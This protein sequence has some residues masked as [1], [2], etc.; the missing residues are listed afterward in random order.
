MYKRHFVSLGFVL[1]AGTISVVQAAEIA[2]LIPTGRINE[3]SSVKARFS[4]PVIR[5]GRADSPDPLLVKCDHPTLKGHGKWSDPSN[6][7]YDF[8]GRV[9]S[10]VT[11]TITPNA[12]FRDLQGKAV[13][14]NSKYT[15]NTGGPRVDYVV[16]YGDQVDEEQ[17]FVI[18]FTAPVNPQSLAQKAVCTATGYG[19]QIPVR[20][21]D[22][23]EKL[24]LLKGSLDYLLDR[25][26][27]VEVVQCSRRLPASGKMQLFIDKGLKG[28]S[29][30]LSELPYE[31]NYE[32]REPFKVSFSCLRENQN[33]ACMPVKPVSLSFNA[34]VPL[35]QAKAIQLEV[36]GKIHSP[37]WQDDDDAPENLV[38]SVRFMPPF[39]ENVAMRVILP[40][41]FRDDAGRV[42]SNA[43]QFPLKSSFGRT[44]PLVKFASSTFGIIE[45]HA[46][47]EPGKSLKE[48]PALVPLTVRNV[49]SNLQADDHLVSPGQVSDFV[50]QS[51]QDVLNW[52]YRVRRLEEA[53]YSPANIRAIMNDQAINWG[54]EDQKTEIDTRSVSILSNKEGV[55]KVDLPASGKNNERE[56]EVIGLPLRQPGFHVLEVKSAHLGQ[57]L[58]KDRNLMYVRTSVLLTN[59]G[60]HVKKGKD[61]FLVWVTTLDDAKPIANA[62]VNVLACDGQ[63]VA[64]GQTDEQGIWHLRKAVKGKDY[65]ESNGMS[66]YFVSARLPENHPMANGVPDYSFAFTSW[67]RGIEPWRFNVPMGY[68]SD[69]LDLKTH[70]VFDRSLFRAGETVSMK[71]FIRTETRDGFALPDVERRPKQLTISHIGSSDTYEIPVEWQPTPSGGLSAVSSWTIPKSAKLGEY[72]ARFDSVGND[73]FSGANFRVEAFKLPLLTGSLKI[74]QPGQEGKAIVAPHKLDLDLQ[75]NYIAGGAAGMLPVTVSAMARDRSVSFADYTDFS[76]EPPRS[77][78][79]DNAYGQPDSA[80]KLFVDK[81]R[82]VLDDKGGARVEITPVPEVKQAKTFTFE[83]SFMD[84]NGEIQTLSQQV[85]AWPANIV[86]GIRTGYYIEKGKNAKIT[87]LAL[88]PAGK[89]VGQTDIRVQA[90]KYTS[91]TVRKRLVGGFYSYDTQQL[92]QDMGTV[93]EG[94]TDKDGRLECE[95]ALAETGRLSLIAEVRDEQGN[96]SRAESGVWVI[97][98]EEL[99]FAGENNDRIDIIPERKEYSAGDKARFQV[100]MPFRQATALLAVEREGVLEARVVNIDGKDPTVSIDIKPEWGPNV[101]VSVLALR[102]RVRSSPGLSLFNW[103]KDTEEVAAPTAMIDLAKPAFRFGLTDIRVQSPAHK[104]YIQLS[105]NKEQYKIRETAQATIK[106]VLPDGKPAA[107]ATVAVAVV[108]QALLELS[109]N[110]SWE[111]LK[112]MMGIRPYSVETATAQL[113]IVGRRHYGRKALPPGG[114]GGI[115]APTR[116]LLDTLLLWKPDIVLDEQGQATIDIPL[117]DVIS[118]FKV[119]A[120]ADHG[121]QLFGDEAVFINTTQDLQIISGLP[122]VVREGD[123][124]QAMVTVRNSSIRDMKMRVQASFTGTAV[125]AQSLPARELALA[126]GSSGQVSWDVLVPTS[127]SIQDNLKL[128]WTL[129]VAETETGDAL[130]QLRFTQAVSPATPVTVRQAAL[131]S[132]TPEAPVNDLQLQVPPESLRKSGRV[133]GG[134]QVQLQPTLSN[135]LQ[136]VRKWFNN[137][138][139]TC[140]EQVSSIAVGLHSPEKWQAIMEQLPSYL[141]QDGLAMYFPSAVLNGDVVLTAYLVSMADEAQKLGIVDGIPAAYRERMLEGLQNYV[142]GKLR[143]N[144][145]APVNDNVERRVLALEALSRYGMVTPSLLTAVKLD[146]QNWSTAALVDWMNIVTRVKGMPN[147]AQMLERIRHALIARMDR[148]GTAMVFADTG[149]NSSWWLMLNNEANMAKLLLAVMGNKAWE[150][151]IPY[152]L[153][154]L[155][156]MQQQGAWST[157]TANLWGTLAVG[158]FSRKFEKTPAQGSVNMTLVPQSGETQ[159]WDN[160]SLNQKVFAPWSNAG[161]ESLSLAKQGPGRVWAT[162]SALA[163]V[164]VTQPA[165]AGYVIEKNIEPVSRASE[166]QWGVGDVYRVKLSIKAKSAMNW[167]IVSDPVPAGATILGSGLGRDSLISTVGE[168]NDYWDGPS[169]V[170]RQA[171]VYRA[172]Y[173]YLPAGESVV[174]YTVRLN[175]PGQFVLPPTRAEAMYAPH[176]YGELPNTNGFEVK[177]Q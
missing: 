42:L 170:E 149:R 151:D 123:R 82:L 12:D 177:G 94:R 134:V 169:F 81:K 26:G 139:Y 52:F 154:G 132:V 116:E 41:D 45:M 28:Q 161:Q 40:A 5:L 166:T 32:V 60:V 23:Q 89:P 128:T 37:S 46:E 48:Q 119:V 65:C 29:G 67:D 124:Y 130:D 136:N 140:L 63:V 122:Q 61:D 157:T 16:P 50:P 47:T 152:M 173:Q 4:E 43:S 9:P 30:L 80:V 164:P 83:A 31:R 138:P 117:N 90:V 111:L 62:Q 160:L 66:G 167:V 55:T 162:V 133:V 6:W 144:T 21:F 49:E 85:A 135:G 131:L 125:P 171:D 24:E 107:G 13:Q 11:C 153:Q 7:S 35:E 72:E 1:L 56:F 168:K 108:D 141:D 76:F 101:Y 163:A 176:V 99:W 121:A 105:A 145:W 172:Y 2:S 118:R 93:C 148:Q 146:T 129:R 39:P 113:E 38:E 36:G 17:A 14:S 27:Q 84:P 19:E 74:V 150:N 110:P 34:P 97:G 92:S 143:R 57:S 109:D 73:Y 100:R 102:G 75:L 98:Q 156:Q 159:S 18:N 64:G 22:Q 79:E 58:L 114:G 112:G 77:L 44:P 158:Q 25:A 20:V 87:A 137:Y 54:N 120:V 78:Q 69:L 68:S 174:E 127:G 104:L 95:V 96:Q 15:F 165:Y 175:T 91:H 126:A 59:M 115:G 70:T 103:G 86:A 88:T 33:Q 8:E 51:D 53:R 142:L 147:R 10:G 106:A 3:V 71:H 155:L